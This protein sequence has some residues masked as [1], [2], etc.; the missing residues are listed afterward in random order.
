M[1]QEGRIN[2]WDQWVISPTSRWGIFGVITQF[3]SFDP[4]RFEV[5]KHAMFF[6]FFFKA[7]HFWDLYIFTCLEVERNSIYA[8]R[9]RLHLESY[10]GDGIGT[11]MDMDS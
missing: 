5:S 7:H 6:P 1:C 3:L 11:G 4:N 10:S 8:L 2:A 9:K